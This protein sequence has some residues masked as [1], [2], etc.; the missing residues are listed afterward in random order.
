LQPFIHS[1]IC[2]SD[3]LAAG[4]SYR[5]CSGSVPS[6]YEKMTPESANGQTVNIGANG[7]FVHDRGK[8]GVRLSEIKDGI[9]HTTAMCERLAGAGQM[10]RFN[11]KRDIW[12]SGVGVLNFA[13]VFDADATSS[14]CNAAE[15]AVTEDFCPWA[16]RY[17]LNASYTN[18]SYNHVLAPN[19]SVPDCSLDLLPYDN[20]FHR[21][22]PMATL[23]AAVKAS[24]F[25]RSGAVNML[26]L[27]GSV[28]IIGA[29][30]DLTIWRMMA[31]RDDAVAILP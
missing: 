27:D 10:D 11:P 23:A 29:D 9:S 4:V 17:Y 19:S 25:H 12:F 15:S 24:S 3:P 31:R 14:I 16:G 26:Y 8:K 20:G 13:Y 18:A 6:I 28:N 5:F 7:A 22:P 21:S 1:M 2:P 30:I